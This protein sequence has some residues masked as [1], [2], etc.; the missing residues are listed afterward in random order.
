MYFVGLICSISEIKLNMFV[1]SLSSWAH[2]MNGNILS[3]MC[4]GKVDC[5]RMKMNI[6]CI[7]MISRFLCKNVSIWT[8]VSIICVKLCLKMDPQRRVAE[9]KKVQIVWGNH[10]LMFF[11]AMY[12]VCLVWL[13]LLSFLIVFAAFFCSNFF[14]CDFLSTCPAGKLSRKFPSISPEGSSLLA[15]ACHSP[16]RWWNSIFKS[17]QKI[18]SP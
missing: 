1:K 10:C 2:G 9:M 17:K 12:C 3:D 11:L 6:N 18:L 14:I 16:L 15:G 8:S 5:I 4:L 13:Q 7:W